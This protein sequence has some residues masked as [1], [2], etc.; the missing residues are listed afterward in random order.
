MKKLLFLFAFIFILFPSNVFAK[1]YSQ[2]YD[3]YWED[4]LQDIQNKGYIL[5]YNKYVPEENAVVYTTYF[6]SDKNDLL[7]LKA[8]LYFWNNKLY[9]IEASF[10][11]KFDVYT[12]KTPLFM[13]TYIDFF[14]TYGEPNALNIKNMKSWEIPPSTMISLIISNDN[15]DFHIL[16]GNYILFNQAQADGAKINQ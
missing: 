2:F 16:W 12:D 7:I 1:E 8:N 13:E 14:K 3:F 6:V 4:S 9:N 15:H 5:T 10:I 11:D